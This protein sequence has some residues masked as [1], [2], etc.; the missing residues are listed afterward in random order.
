MAFLNSAELQNI[1][2]DSPRATPKAESSKVRGIAHRSKERV[3]EKGKAIP[4]DDKAKKIVQDE[5]PSAR[6]KPKGKRKAPQV[7]LAEKSLVTA[8]TGAL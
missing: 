3:K 8:K 4:S 7:S 2:E 5:V 6:P 1:I